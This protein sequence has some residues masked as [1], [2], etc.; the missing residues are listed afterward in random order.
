MSP[1]PHA[2]GVA[3]A[4]K[5][6]YI[7]AQKSLKGLNQVAARQMAKGD[8]ST[9]ELLAGRGKEIRE[10][11]TEVQALRKRWREV[12]GGGAAA[13]KKPKTALWAYYQPILQG[14]VQAGGECGLPELEPLVE[15]IMESSLQPGD[16]EP[17]SK[18]RERWRV[19]VQRARRPM[20][21]EGWIE[22]RPLKVWRITDDGRKAAAKA[23]GQGAVGRR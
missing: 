8:Y 13:A 22:A 17:V 7:A 15:R 20:V 19:M 12:C 4:I 14:L 18:G 23:V 21:G 5:G 16:L 3:Q 10:F 1:V 2:A 11:Q 9:A 6:V